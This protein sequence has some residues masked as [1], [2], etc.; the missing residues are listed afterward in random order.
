MPSNEL[1]SVEIINT[2][3][4]E[5][6]ESKRKRHSPSPMLFVLIPLYTACEKKLLYPLVKKLPTGL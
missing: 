3:L 5:G 2:L 6:K 1:T 4:F